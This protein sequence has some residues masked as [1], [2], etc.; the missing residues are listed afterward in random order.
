M[1]KDNKVTVEV[2]PVQ[3]VLHLIPQ[4]HMPDRELRLMA[5]LV[6]LL[7][8]VYPPPAT[9][10]KAQGSAI[11]PEVQRAIKWLAEKY[12]V[13]VPAPAVDNGW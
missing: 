10:N 3:E 5:N 13:E 11:R 1:S 7:E 6:R 4:Q 8:N 9:L 2:D 12:E